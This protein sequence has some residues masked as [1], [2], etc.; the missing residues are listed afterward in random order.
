LA[1]AGQAAQDAKEQFDAKRE[2]RFFVSVALGAASGFGSA[3]AFSK[4]SMLVPFLGPYFVAE[5]APEVFL[6]APAFGALKGGV[7]NLIIDPFRGAAVQTIA[8]AKA[9]YSCKMTNVMN[10]IRVLR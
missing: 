3:V 6:V 5:T 9:Y 1:L 4:V 2:K 7:T 10:Q 8:A